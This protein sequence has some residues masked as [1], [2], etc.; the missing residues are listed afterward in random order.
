MA[1]RKAT[2]RPHRCRDPWGAG[3]CSGLQLNWLEVTAWLALKKRT[4]IAVGHRAP[5]HL[6][7]LLVGQR[8]LHVVQDELKQVLRVETGGIQTGGQ[9]L[10]PSQINA[11]TSHSALLPFGDQI[12]EPHKRRPVEKDEI[13]PVQL[14]RLVQDLTSHQEVAAW[15]ALKK[16]TTIAVG[17]RAPR[18]LLQLLVGQRMLHVVQDELKQ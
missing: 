3:W 16:R 1:P 9:E 7:Q 10:L 18:H 11:R 15:L 4:T 14:P 17:H 2:G 13:V 12:N 6:L 8:M 5:R